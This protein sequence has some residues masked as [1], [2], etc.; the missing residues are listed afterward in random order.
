MNSLDVSHFSFRYET[1]QVLSEI[2]F[3]VESREIVGLVGA[4]GSGKS[5]LLW[6]IAG[7]LKGQGDIR[8]FGES[9]RRGL[10]RIGMVFQNPEDQLF[11]P[12][13]AQDLAGRLVNTGHERSIAEARA[14]VQLRRFGLED[15]ADRPASV[16]SL[17]QRKRAAI[18]AAMITSPDLLLVDE[19]TAELD[20]RAI[21]ELV[22]VL[23]NDGSAKL[24][25]SHHVEFLAKVVSRVIVLQDGR[26]A[27]DGSASSILED[28]GLLEAAGLI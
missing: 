4:N 26:I 25:A 2:T 16:L 20:G 9:P 28:R 12:S 22:T 24:I 6:A 11:M 18:A 15:S 27:A 3:S 5:T 13:L 8:I 1:R 23:Q 7:L 17:G 10:K 19:P 14:I 21:R